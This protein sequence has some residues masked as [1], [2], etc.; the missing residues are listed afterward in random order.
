MA[1]SDLLRQDLND[2]PVM[3]LTPWVTHGMTLHD[4]YSCKMLGDTLKSL[5]LLLIGETKDKVL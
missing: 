4:L 3:S 5:I 2:H 1:L